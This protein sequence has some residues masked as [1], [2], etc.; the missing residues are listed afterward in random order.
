[1]K[2]T[3]SQFLALRILVAALV[4]PLASR[5]EAQEVASPLSD[6]TPPQPRVL[7]KLYTFDGTDA[8]VSAAARS[9]RVQMMGMQSGFL[10]NPLGLDSDDDVSP[11]VA[12]EAS[13]PENPGEPEVLQLNVG[14]HN[15]YL[16]LRLPGDPGGLG[17]YKV[18]S[19]LQLVD[20]GS[21][22]FCLNLQAYTPAGMNNGGLANGPTTFVPT[23]AC[24][25]DLGNGAALQTYFG[26]N[27]QAASGWT[28]RIN[29]NFQYGMAIQYPLP[30]TSSTGEQGLFV[31]LE[32][33]GRYRY[34]PSQSN[35]H[36]ALW[37][38]VPGVQMRLSSNCWMNV[39]A[40]HYNFLSASWRY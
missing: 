4:L 28:D 24:F 2:V 8:V 3:R 12:A 6:Q 1:M 5:V 7:F 26:Q 9:A 22:S 20:A 11:S 25:Q 18:H 21:T 38:F 15:P 16:D 13:A 23:L 32:A 35:G 29:T 30:G 40:S 14:N 19:Q 36:V 39:A 10:V 17:Y 27:I 37:E 34:D 31:F 33:L